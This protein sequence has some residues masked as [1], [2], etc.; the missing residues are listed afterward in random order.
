MMAYWRAE[1]PE[2]GV[3]VRYKHGR[4]LVG[5]RTAKSRLNW[6][7]ITESQFVDDAAIYATSRG[8]F[9]SATVKLSSLPPSGG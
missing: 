6:I 1:C 2:V 7:K 3:M 8:A 5:D 4:K 9:E